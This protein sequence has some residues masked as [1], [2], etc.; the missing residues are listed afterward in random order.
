MENLS[1]EEALPRVMDEK[2]IAVD[3]EVYIETPEN[4]LVVFDINNAEM[5]H[6]GIMRNRIMIKMTWGQARQL[7]KN[8]YTSIIER[9]LIPQLV[10]SPTSDYIH[11][12]AER[13]EEI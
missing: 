7:L 8:K 1:F 12:T 6:Y 9:G 4:G 2:S 3:S 13:N 11:L 5:L 10:Y